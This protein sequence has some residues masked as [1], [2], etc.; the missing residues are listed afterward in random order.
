MF[1]LKADFLIGWLQCTEVVPTT[2]HTYVDRQVLSTYDSIATSVKPP[3][4]PYE[5]LQGCATASA[6]SDKL[7]RHCKAAWHRPVHSQAGVNA[8][9]TVGN[10]GSR[11]KAGSSFL[12]CA[13]AYDWCWGFGRGWTSL[14]HL[15]RST[16]L[17]G[18]SSNVYWWT[19]LQA[20][21]PS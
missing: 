19:W 13:R 17:C 9:M 8:D 18:K 6:A 15:R 21:A 2:R 4:T 1:Q 14:P 20:A 3:V 10:H 7:C 11:I 5:E 16:R 12:F